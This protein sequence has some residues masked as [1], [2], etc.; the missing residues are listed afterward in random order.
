MTKMKYPRMV[1]ILAKP[2]VRQGQLPPCGQKIENYLSGRLNH[3]QINDQSTVMRHED[4]QEEDWKDVGPLLA[5][6]SRQRRQADM[7]EDISRR[8]AGKRFESHSQPSKRESQGN[9]GY[10]NERS[11]QVSSTAD[12]HGS[13][14]TY[15]VLECS[16]WNRAFGDFRHIFSPEHG[17]KH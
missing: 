4:L 8:P 17:G 1:E 15:H 7:L 2:K 11:G 5:P 3:F 12:A 9:S 6:R 14:P 10:S 13:V 16:S